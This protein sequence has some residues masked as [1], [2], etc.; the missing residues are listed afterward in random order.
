[1]RDYNSGVIS[2]HNSYLTASPYDGEE[3]EEGDEEPGAID[4][5]VPGIDDCDALF[6]MSSRDGRDTV[7]LRCQKFADGIWA[8]GTID[9][10]TAHFCEDIGFLHGP[11][12]TYEE[13]FWGAGEVFDWFGN[14]GIRGYWCD[15]SKKLVRRAYDKARRARKET[16]ASDENVK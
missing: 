12:A 2:R 9:C 11:F 15:N 4:H 16:K 13:A 10:D 14:N 5:D 3:Y 6:C 7:Y 1:M 8:Q